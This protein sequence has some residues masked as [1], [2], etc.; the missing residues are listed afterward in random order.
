MTKIIFFDFD[1][2]LYSHYT[3]CIPASCVEALN[4][5][6]KK[7]IKVF[8]CS[9]R[10]LFELSYFDLSMIHVDGMI[11]NNGQLIYDENNNIIYKHPFEGKLKE[12][13]IDKFN[14]KKVP[15]FINSGKMNFTNY[16]NDKVIQ[17][18]N[19]INSPVPPIKE[20]EGEDIF[21]CSAF[22]SN[23]DDWDDLLGLKEYA[24]ITYWHDGA[25]DIIPNDIN[26]AKGI[27]IVLNYYGLSKQEAIGVGDSEN[28]VNMLKYCNI[29]IAVG[30]GTDEAKKAA[31]Y[32]TDHIEENGIYN[33]LKHYNII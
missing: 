12:L 7:G 24:N 4:E 2:T 6:H 32:I 19:D 14:Q 28:D 23:P 33:A 15:I 20:Y 30:N 11:A 21:M 10:S 26:K 9:G 5:L 1:G 22:Y 3:N 25:V 18:Q 31:D 29:G 16:I 17:T 13:I 8:L 27:E